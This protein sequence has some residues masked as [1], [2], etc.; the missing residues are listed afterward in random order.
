MTTKPAQKFNVV[1]LCI[2]RKKTQIHERVQC[3]CAKG[4]ELRETKRTDRCEKEKDQLGHSS[5]VEKRQELL[6]KDALPVTTEKRAALLSAVLES[7]TARQ[8]LTLHSFILSPEEQQQSEINQAI[9]KDARSLINNLT[10]ADQRITV[11]QCS[12]VFLYF[13]TETVT[14][15]KIQ[16]LVAETRQNILK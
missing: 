6:I 13:V 16:K 14:E 7:P 15:K 10:M 12:V 2:P 8:T 3:L 4:E 9:V 1:C 5:I 11:L